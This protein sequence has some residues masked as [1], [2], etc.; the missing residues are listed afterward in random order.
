MTIQAIDMG[1]RGSRFL[2]CQRCVEYLRRAWQR[3]QTCIMPDL[4][5]VISSIFINIA[6]CT[7]YLGRL[8]I[9]NFI[10]DLREEGGEKEKGRKKV[11]ELFILY[12]QRWNFNW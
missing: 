10:K 6:T 2:A 9:S 4:I 3:G 7:V 8:E 5:A 12:I 11:Y 1:L